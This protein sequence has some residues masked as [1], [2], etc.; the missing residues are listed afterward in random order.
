MAELSGVLSM[1]K[2]YPELHDHMFESAVDS[3]H[4]VRLVKCVIVAAML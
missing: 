1:N 4:F 3:N 2:L